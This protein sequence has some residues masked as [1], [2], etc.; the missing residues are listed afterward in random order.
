MRTAQ[1]DQ[2]GMTTFGSTFTDA[3]AGSGVASNG[4]LYTYVRAA[5]GAYTFRFDTGLTPVSMTASGNLA[6]VQA[7]AFSALGPGTFTV[8]TLT[9]NAAANGNGS[10]LC[11]ARDKR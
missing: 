5:T 4:I 7:A 11:T 9:A 10:W 6:S 8:H 1:R 3:A 2:T